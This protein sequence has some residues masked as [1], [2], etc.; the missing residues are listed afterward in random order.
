ML[1]VKGEN[2]KIFGYNCSA[3]PLISGTEY[4]FIG[5]FENRQI[6]GRWTSVSEIFDYIEN[7]LKNDRNPASYK[8]Y[9]NYTQ[10][11]I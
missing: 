3:T 11:K 10:N 6:S 2:K 1:K 8:N 9:C 4:Y 7:M 5:M